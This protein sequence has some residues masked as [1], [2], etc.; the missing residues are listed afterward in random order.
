MARRGV[1]D[2][3][4]MAACVSDGISVGEVARGDCGRL[5]AG[6]LDSPRL[7]R[8]ARAMGRNPEVDRMTYNWRL[9]TL[10]AA[11]CLITCTCAF[12]AGVLAKSGF[13]LY[14]YGYALCNSARTNF[15]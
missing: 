8:T 11:S 3:G 12:V 4:R 10:Q 13:E 5:L 9:E 2:L 7:S 14:S 15:R 1:C 6:D